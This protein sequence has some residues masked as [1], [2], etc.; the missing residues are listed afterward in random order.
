MK[1]FTMENSFLDPKSLE[2][3]WATN[4]RWKGITRNYSA[5]DV[6]SIRNSVDI[7]YTLAEKGAQNLFEALN[8]KDE[9][10]SALGA[11]SGNQAVQMVKAGLRAIYLSGWQVAADSNLGETTYPD[12]SLYPSNSAPTLAKRINNALLRAEQVDR[13]EGNNSI[14]Y[15]VPIV[16]DGEAGFGGT[17]NVFE[18][19]KKFI[20]AGAAGVHFEDQLAAEKKCGHMG[21]KVLVPTSQ[22]IRTLTSARLASDTL[23]VPTVIIARTDALAANLVTSDIDETDSDFVLGE[24]TSEGFFKVKNGPEAAI[25]RGLSYAPY[26]DLVWCETGKPDIGFAKEFADAIREKFPDKLLAYNCSPSFNWKQSLS[27]E[28][29]ATFQ[30]KLSSFGYKFQFITLAGFHA[31]NT[32]MFELAMNYKGGNMSAYV[33]LQ[34]KEFALEK[35][36][37]TSVKHQREV[38]AGYFDTISTIISGG[39]ASTLALEGSTEEEQF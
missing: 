9:W 11:L 29:I 7:K 10:I 27:D 39:D 13:V 16:A 28:E 25:S 6:V 30:E 34:Q 4:P 2:N 35:D 22:H 36:G 12:Q 33:E 18:L 31:L 20:E 38:G 14:D 5:E 32:S 21:G 19:T 3:D 23:G 8:K 26:A 1:V 15:L 24:R 17:L 37:F